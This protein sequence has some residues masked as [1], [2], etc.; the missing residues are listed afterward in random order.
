MTLVERFYREVY[1]P[2]FAAHREPLEA[3]QRA[4][5]GEA[6]YRMRLRI[7]VDGD[8]IQGGLASELYPRSACGLVTYLVVAPAWRGRGLGRRWLAEAAAE[9][10]AEGARAVFGEVDRREPERL[11]R[12]R[13]WGARAVDV[14]YVQPALGEGLARDRELVLIALDEPRAELPGELVRAFLA[15]FYEATEGALDPELRAIVA[16]IP[17]VVSAW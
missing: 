4:L 13:R 10:R 7:E 11:A 1:L 2:E 14:P 17:E 3:W 6:P 5:A 15:E 9:L 8:Q 16:G 12:F